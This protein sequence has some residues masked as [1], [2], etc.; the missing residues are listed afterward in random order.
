MPSSSLTVAHP[1]HGIHPFQNTD[2]SLVTCYIEMTQNSDVKL[3]VDKTSGHIMID[4]PMKFTNFMPCLYGFIPQTYCDTLTANFAGEALKKLDVSGDFS[5]DLDPLDICVFTDRNPP[6]GQFL[7]TAKIIG[8]LCMIDSGEVDD[9]II[10]VL[11][12]DT[13]Y[14]E[15]TELSDL[16]NKA[17][18]KI[19]HYFLTYKEQPNLDESQDNSKEKATAKK[20]DKKVRITHTYGAEQAQKIVLLSHKDYQAAFSQP[21]SPPSLVT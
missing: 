8:G 14:G 2:K 12:D 7:V 19:L 13:V 9:K 21:P 20:V 3:E 6:S 17:L 10:A 15:M 16:P 11:C 5:G 1:W 18:Q 4:R